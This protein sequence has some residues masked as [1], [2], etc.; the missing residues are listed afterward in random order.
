MTASVALSFARAVVTAPRTTFTDAVRDYQDEVYGVA[1][2][3]TGDRESAL[4]VTST[5]FLKA[6]RAFARYDQ[7][8]PI[9]ESADE[10]ADATA[11]PEAASLAREERDLIRAAVAQLP[12][13]YRS[14][15]VLRYFNELSIDEIAAVTERPASTVGVQLL[16]GRTLL[17]RALEGSA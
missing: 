8:R 6:Y 4:D 13:L 17:R 9:R 10:V 15:I 12:E 14:V 3:I 7:T 11:A 5:T 2:R 1:L 16:R